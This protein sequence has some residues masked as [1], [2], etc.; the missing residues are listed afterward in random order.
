MASTNT[1]APAAAS[2]VSDA[3]A[4]TSSPNTPSTPISR[5]PRLRSLSKTFEESD[6]PQG[7]LTA[8]GSIASS[9]V[10]TPGSR[11]RGSVAAREAASTWLGTR[12][13]EDASPQE[14][15]EHAHHDNELRQAQGAAQ[16]VPVEQG[17]GR[18]ARNG[19][20]GGCEGQEEHNGARNEDDE[21]LAT[22]ATKSAS[23][24]AGAEKEPARRTDTAPF[25]NGYH[26]PPSHD[27]ATSLK[28]GLTEFGRFAITPLGAVVVLYGL[29]VVAFGGMI[30]LLLCNAAPAMCY[31]SCNH[32]DSPRRVWIEI[33]SQILNAL[34]CVTGFGLAPWRFRD[35]YFLMQFR[36]RGGE[37]GLRRLA[38]IHRGW[39]RL[40]G[41]E[42]L[43]GGLGPENVEASLDEG[44]APQVPFP[45]TSIP[46]APLSG[47]R[48]PPTKTWKMD[49]M[50]W[51]NCWNTFMQALLSGFMWGLNRYDRPSWSTGL[52]V[53]LA[54]VFAAAGG[55]VS[56][57]EG[58]SV[59]GIEGVP[60][61]EA[62]QKRLAHDRELNIPHYVSFFTRLT[63]QLGGVANAD[64]QE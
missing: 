49:L 25:D 47:T 29:L 24:S 45:V 16:D 50:V 41:S 40:G 55:L 15:D 22:S 37:R 51:A 6:L 32:I 44:M 26:F 62:D 14:A 13:G 36:V 23:T 18:G 46:D 4:P 9:V 21:D 1:T 17:A 33:D 34:F 54:I 63:L 20:A 8:T 57:F 28:L 11:R 53:G 48:A 30:F 58:K 39:F 10:T 3:G 60:L 38:G 61:T 27:F 43:P 12:T 52:F 64:L 5:T 2:A 59:K 31:P 42:G 7:F 35:L 19:A 56:F